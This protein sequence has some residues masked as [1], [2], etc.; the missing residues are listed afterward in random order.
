MET[1][2]D[3]VVVTNVRLPGDVCVLWGGDQLLSYDEDVLTGYVA[4]GVV[5]LGYGVFREA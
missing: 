1:G 2:L 3:G 4:S 5:R